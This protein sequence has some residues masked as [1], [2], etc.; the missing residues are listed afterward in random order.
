L[1]YLVR[2]PAGRFDIRESVATPDGPR[3]H[4]L[5]SFRG[6]LTPEVLDGAERRASRPFD[7]ARLQARAVELGV[8]VTERREDRA[9]RGLLAALRTGTSIDPVLLS[10][11][12]QIVGDLPAEPV[13]AALADVVEWV[14][15]D[16]ARRGAALRDLLRLSDR[17]VRARRGV[18]T[19]PH[20]PF[21]RF[22]SRRGRAA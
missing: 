22:R 4:T 14:G 11:L 10:I 2:R 19:R 17:I 8:T 21:P 16:E 5:A 9:A 1:A 7:R 18:R 12:K 15:V 3:S 20:V 13:P 6:A